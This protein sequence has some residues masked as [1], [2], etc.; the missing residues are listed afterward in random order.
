[1]DKNNETAIYHEV[2]KKCADLYNSFNVILSKKKITGLIGSPKPVVISVR[3]IQNFSNAS[4]VLNIEDAYN[5][6]PYCS[7]IAENTP[8]G[9]GLFLLNNYT[10]ERVDCLT[11][12]EKKELID[13]LSEVS[14]IF[15]YYSITLKSMYFEYIGNSVDC[16]LDTTL[17]RISFH[18]DNI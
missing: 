10:G 15:S 7:F 18:V 14:G 13:T 1:M 5:T 6:K 9:F 11:S 8:D 4:L 16:I 2:A 3:M 12:T 17:R